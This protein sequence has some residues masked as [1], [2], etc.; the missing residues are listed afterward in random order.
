M[1]RYRASRIKSRLL[2]C[3]LSSLK[4]G[5]LQ[6]SFLFSILRRRTSAHAQ[7]L[8]RRLTRTLIRL[9]NFF[10]NMRLT[11]RLIFLENF[12]DIGPLRYFIGLYLLI[13][14]MRRS[15]LCFFLVLLCK[16]LA[17]RVILAHTSDGTQGLIRCL[18]VIFN[19]RREF[20][21]KQLR[22]AR[23]CFVFQ[24]AELNPFTR[25]ATCLLKRAGMLPSLRK[26]EA[27]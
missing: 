27:R 19:L 11:R 26:V 1:F 2:K 7:V 13:A 17:A 12:L 10:F 24:N 18:K 9:L 16:R 25:C 3:S 21:F 6:T 14:A 20:F 4:S 23:W 5:A 8:C 15:A 22:R